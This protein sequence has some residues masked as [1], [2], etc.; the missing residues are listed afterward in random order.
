MSAR[1]VVVNEAFLRKFSK[2]KDLI[3]K[4]LRNSSGKESQIVGVVGDVRDAGLDMPASPRVYSSIFQNSGFSLAVFLRTR[5]D[6]AVIKEALTRTVNRVDPELPVFGV[7]TMHELMSASMAR[8]R[9]ALSLMAV[10][11]GL[12]LFLA[13]IGIYGVMAFVVGQRTQEFGV[14]MALGAQQRD[15]LVLAFR[16]GLVLTS[17]GAVA[18]VAVSIGAMR[19]MSSLLF[20]VS[21]FDPFTFAGVPILLGAVALISCWLPAWRATHIPPGVALRS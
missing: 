15:I 19:L 18:G 9:F 11:A 6:A 20:S 5:S 10:F 1:V 8:R 14:R 2:H 12:A 16:P 7:R 4:R 3:G 13:A 21:P 17:I